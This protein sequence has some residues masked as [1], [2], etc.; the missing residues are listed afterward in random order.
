VLEQACLQL[1]E[2]LLVEVRLPVFIEGVE[3]ERLRI[4]DFGISRRLEVPDR[5]DRSWGSTM[6]CR[7]HN[8]A[9]CNQE[10][11]TSDHG[12][13]AARTFCLG[14]RAVAKSDIRLPGDNDRPIY[15]RGDRRRSGWSQASV[16]STLNAKVNSR[17]SVEVLDSGVSGEPLAHEWFA[18]VDLRFIYDSQRGRLTVFFLQAS[19][20]RE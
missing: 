6:P 19:R 15:R 8:N 20:N 17:W 16:P 7:L 2:T 9:S 18:V 5:L 14:N 1:P 13:S 12:R 11:R 10:C 4:C 3:Q